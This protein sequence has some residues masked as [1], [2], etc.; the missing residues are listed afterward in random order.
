MNLSF[1]RLIWLLPVVFLAH[2]L[3]EYVSGF[4]LYAGII[5]GHAMPLPLFIGSNGAFIAIM[6][7]LTRWTARARSAR[8]IFWLFAWAAGNQFWN[9]V[10]HL[11]CVPA[12]DRHSPGLITASLIY[13]PLSLALWQAA[14]VEKLIRPSALLGAIAAGGAYMGA[15]A[16]F[17]IFHL[18]GL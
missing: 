16:A 2:V 3:E 10:F 1:Y 14:L 8:A 13:L 18:G 12:F 4:P 17:G 9:F 5:S 6:A 15:V 11:L 7:L